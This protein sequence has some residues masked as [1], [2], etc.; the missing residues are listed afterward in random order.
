MTPQGARHAESGRNV[1]KYR[2]YAV[3]ALALFA[4]LD[5]VFFGG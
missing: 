2:I 5:K 3:D 1:T 4:L